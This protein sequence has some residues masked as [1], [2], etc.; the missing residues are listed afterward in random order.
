MNYDG[1]RFGL[2]ILKEGSDTASLCI[3]RRIGGIIG[4]GV[5]VKFVLLWYIDTTK[6]LFLFGN[7]VM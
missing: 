7:G 4:R 6:S 1:F 2:Y 3:L 5:E